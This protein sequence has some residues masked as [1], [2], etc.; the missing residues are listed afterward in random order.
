MAVTNFTF[1]GVVHYRVAQYF[2]KSITNSPVSLKRKKSS[3]TLDGLQYMYSNDCKESSRTEALSEFD[4]GSFSYGASK[5]S[6]SKKELELK[7][8]RLLPRSW[9]MKMGKRDVKE[10]GE[11]NGSDVLDKLKYLRTEM[12]K[13]RR[14]DLQTFYNIDENWVCSWRSVNAIISVINASGNATEKEASGRIFT[15]RYATEI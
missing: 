5:T 9:R 13:K 6:S 12:K 8:E 11:K 15:N 2:L 3:R 1:I 14:M 10:K 4:W 7:K